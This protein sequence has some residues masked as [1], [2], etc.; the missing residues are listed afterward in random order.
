MG[1][2]KW[3]GSILEQQETNTEEEMLE[4]VLL[5]ERLCVCGVAVADVL[6]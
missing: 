3:G 5:V 6:N 4:I 2:R 1:F